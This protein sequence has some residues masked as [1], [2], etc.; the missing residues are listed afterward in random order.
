[1]FVSFGKGKKEMKIPTDGSAIQ[2]VALYKDE[3]KAY[4][5]RASLSNNPSFL[6]LLFVTREPEKLETLNNSE[7]FM[8]K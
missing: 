4:F 8:T 5:F 2:F 3:T 7:L 6:L 1:M